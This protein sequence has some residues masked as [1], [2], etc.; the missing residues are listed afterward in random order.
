MTTIDSQ[1]QKKGWKI[2]AK[3]DKSVLYYNQ[4]K[5]ENNVYITVSTSTPVHQ[6]GNLIK[7][8]KLMSWMLSLAKNCP[9]GK[10]ALKKGLT[11]TN[12]HSDKKS[13]IEQ[14][15][16]KNTSN[17][18]RT[19]RR[20][21]ASKASDRINR[22]SRGR[23]SLSSSSSDDSRI[24]DLEDD[25]NL[26]KSKQNNVK[27]PTV[28][29]SCGSKTGLQMEKSKTTTSAISKKLVKSS[30]DADSDF[31]TRKATSGTPTPT[32]AAPSGRES[33]FKPA[34]PIVAAATTTSSS[35]GHGGSSGSGDLNP[36]PS[37]SVVKI[38]LKRKTQ[39]TLDS[40]LEKLQKP[41]K[42]KVDSLEEKENNK[43]APGRGNNVK[44]T[45]PTST[46]TSSVITL[47]TPS[48][49]KCHGRNNWPETKLQGQLFQALQQHQVI[50]PIANQLRVNAIL[51][52]LWIPWKWN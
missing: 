42:P 10:S 5:S 37:T 49:N 34:T 22:E 9:C 47:N 13:G 38:A 25:P 14:N 20:A 41:K 8:F 44:P 52:I 17:S 51:S 35:M 45:T 21:A 2:V 36:R 46:V 28:L 29:P 15:S 26:V 11:K 18:S 31:K 40:S 23:L 39:T 16:I 50:Q 12:S 7:K 1:L 19:H 3:C 24:S 30:S 27:S 4:N 48:L 33:N 6:V 32:T 43:V